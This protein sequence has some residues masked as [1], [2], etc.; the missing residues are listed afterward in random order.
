M[1]NVL[2]VI[3]FTV[4][5]LFSPSAPAKSGPEISIFFV[6][7]PEELTAAADKKCKLQGLA[8]SAQFYA[9]QSKD[10]KRAI[11]DL[12][13]AVLDC[14]DRPVFVYGKNLDHALMVSLLGHD[15]GDGDPLFCGWRYPRSK[16]SKKTLFDGG[17]AAWDEPVFS[18]TRMREL[19]TWL[20]S[21]P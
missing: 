19:V 11:E 13:G 10:Q 1:A 18:E 2:P 8:V 12:V 21:R 17:V 3:A 14:K 16:D 4:L 6:S 9:S 15:M 5:G 7:T 20:W